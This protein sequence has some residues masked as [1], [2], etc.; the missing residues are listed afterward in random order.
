MF[1]TFYL[2]RLRSADGSLIY[3]YFTTLDEGMGYFLVV[4]MVKNPLFPEAG[5]Y[6]Y[7]SFSLFYH[8]SFFGFFVLP[9]AGGSCYF[10]LCLFYH[11]SFFGF[12]VPYG[13]AC[14][15]IG[16]FMGAGMGA[17]LGTRSNLY[18]SSITKS[19]SFY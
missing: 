19:C 16:T 17:G 8:H 1:S 4:E 15:V 18:S 2:L 5:G 6:C 12:F 10:S 3:Y 7:F 11:H 9:E 14:A 13:I